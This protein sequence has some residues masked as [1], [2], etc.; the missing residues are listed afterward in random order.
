MEVLISRKF[1]VLSGE[2]Q[3]VYFATQADLCPVLRAMTKLGPAT[4]TVL[5]VTY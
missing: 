4:A 2:G 5:V 1:A 3:A